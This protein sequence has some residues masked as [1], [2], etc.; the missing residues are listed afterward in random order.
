MCKTF[1]SVGSSSARLVAPR[2][3]RRFAFVPPLFISHRR[4]RGGAL[5]A[6]GQVGASLCWRL[7]GLFH[8]FIISNDHT[9]RR[10]RISGYYFFQIKLNISLCKPKV[11]HF[12]TFLLMTVFI[13]DCSHAALLVENQACLYT[14]V[15]I[16]CWIFPGIPGRLPFQQSPERRRRTALK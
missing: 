2:C 13:P 14:H 3:S 11:L 12:F 7:E 15:H 4:R 9:L 6:G 5:G 10:M 1:I 8:H 16:L